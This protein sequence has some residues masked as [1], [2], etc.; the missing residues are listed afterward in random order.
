MSSKQAIDEHTM[1]Q[2]ISEGD[3][4]AFERF[5][6]AYYQPIYRFFRQRGIERIDAEDLA[7]DVFVNVWKHRLNIDPKQSLRGYLFAAAYNRLKMHFRSKASLDANQE[8][9]AIEQG[10]ASE[11]PIEEFDV[12]EHINKA[13]RELPEF[14]K[15]VFVMHRYDGL[16][17]KEIAQVLNIATKTVEGRMSRALKSLRT[18][19]RHLLS[20]IAVALTL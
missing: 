13:V 15:A 6:D 7:Q 9:F 3:P 8:R 20:L 17:Y 12:N 10:T 4:A 14:Q 18:A 5:F 2:R 1:C 11:K 19:L 16:S